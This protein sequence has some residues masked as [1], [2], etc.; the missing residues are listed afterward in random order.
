MDP[1]GQR[2][3]VWHHEG[4]SVAFPFD[5]AFGQYKSPESNLTIT[6][7]G[8]SVSQD[9]LCDG[10]AKQ[11]VTEHRSF[12]IT[13]A[14]GTQYQF[15]VSPVTGESHLIW[16]AGE[17]QAL[18]FYL[19]SRIQDRWGRELALTWEG[20]AGSSP[21]PRVTH[22][23]DETGTIRLTFTNQTVNRFRRLESVTDSL[24]RTHSFG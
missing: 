7:S 9:Y 12:V 15:N 23:R 13:D 16:R 1:S 11:M 20:T 4:G 17:C 2:Y 5:A 6:A 18:P 19:L 3:A 8:P 10:L 21:E 14:A 24:G 22:V